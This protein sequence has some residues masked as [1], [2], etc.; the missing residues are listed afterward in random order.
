MGR[1]GSFFQN[2][3]LKTAIAIQLFYFY[4]TTINTDI[5]VNL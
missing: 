1:Y 2:H 3:I 4:F 5:N